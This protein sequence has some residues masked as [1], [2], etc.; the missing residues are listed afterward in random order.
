MSTPYDGNTTDVRLRT[1][2]SPIPTADLDLT[3]PIPGCSIPGTQT[4]F[5]TA[6]VPVT[7]GSILATI[8]DGDTAGQVIDKWNWQL[9]A[10]QD[11]V[12]PTGLD[13]KSITNLILRILIKHFAEVDEDNNLIN[14][15]NPNLS[16]LKF[17]GDPATSKIRI[18]VNTVF[19]FASALTMPA[20]II[21]RGALKSA[22]VG[23]GDCVDFKE[24]SDG[25]T[26]SME[27]VRTVSGSHSVLVA[28]ALD[29]EVEELATEVFDLLTR[30]SPAIR[31]I[32]PFL[33]FQ[34]EDMS[35][36]QLADEGGNKFVVG[37]NI[38]YAYEHGW[39]TCYGDKGLTP[40]KGDAAV[41]ANLLGSVGIPV[42]LT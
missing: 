1:D 28:S 41:N 31:A 37:I 40:Y 20:L 21:K 5:T 27:Y 25:E 14:V 13:N 26:Q 10:N 7:P 33:D 19:D 16:E 23:I 18:A 3:Q 22:R 30:L 4:Y 6:Q 9:P 15:T 34:I 29:G 35:E 11:E 24:S 36:V 38:S 42:T 32:Y 39:T 8:P 12:C 2:T 17:T